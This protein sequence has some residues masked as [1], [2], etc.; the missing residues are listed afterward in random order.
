MPFLSLL[1][2]ASCARA[3]DP[4]LPTPFAACPSSPNCVSTRESPDDA[5]H[6]IAPIPVVGDADAFWARVGEVVGGLPRA[7][8]A[9]EGPD[10]RHYVFTTAVM[11]FRDDVQLELD[12]T[13]GLLHFR[14][15][16]R[17]GHSDLGVNRRRMEA[18]REALAAP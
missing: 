16:S 12:R 1:I 13:G 9:D 7:R 2:A 17:V 10:H 18:I 8:L 5:E 3:P 4:A 15:A 11:R 14:S 6:W